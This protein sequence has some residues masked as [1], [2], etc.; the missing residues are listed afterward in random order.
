MRSAKTWFF[1]SCSESVKN[2]LLREGVDSRYGAAPF[3][4]CDRT[5]SCHAT[6]K[7]G[8]EWAGE[9]R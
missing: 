2:V 6:V 3:E 1:F 5:T 4:A 7:L 9:C 8:G